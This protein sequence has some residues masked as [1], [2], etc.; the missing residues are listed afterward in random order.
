MSSIRSKARSR[1]SEFT[2]RADRLI[3]AL[4][5]GPDS[6]PA[7]DGRI[8][9]GTA[10]NGFEELTRAFRTLAL[11][12]ELAQDRTEVLDS[13]ARLR[14]AI[15]RNRARFKGWVSSEL[16][17]S[18]AWF[19]DASSNLA[20]DEPEEVLD[21][22]SCLDAAQA[23]IGFLESMGIDISNSQARL[24]A[25]LEGIRARAQELPYFGPF[26]DSDPFGPSKEQW[27]WFLGSQ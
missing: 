26:D 7:S 19:E 27:W 5:T 9:W 22:W 17:K 20:E 13:M 21:V 24:N 11:D 8:P 18:I 14:G 15:D 4:E 12:V 25:V 6:L 16:E 1:A 2:K 3:R 23:L 10:L